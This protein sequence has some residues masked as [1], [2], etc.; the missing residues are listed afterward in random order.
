[1]KKPSEVH[2]VILSK[3]HFEKKND[4]WRNV[5]FQGIKIDYLD[6]DWKSY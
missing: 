6:G 3:I 5:I 4:D 2:Q 1:M